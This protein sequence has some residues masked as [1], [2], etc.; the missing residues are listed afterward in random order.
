MAKTISGTSSANTLL[1]LIG[2]DLIYGYADN[3]KLY[4]YGGRDTLDGGLGADTLYGGT[5]ADVY[6]VDNVLDRVVEPA[7]AAH[8]IRLFSIG[9]GGQWSNTFSNLTSIEFGGDGR[10]VLF[11]SSASNVISGDTNAEFDVFRKD[12][13]TGIIQRVSVSGSGAQGNDS[14]FNAAMTPD[15]RYIAFESYAS[16]LVSN[17]TN[18]NTDIFLRDMVGGTLRRISTGANGE[19]V[20]TFGN[21]NPDITGNGRYV[22]FDSVNSY[23]AGDTNGTYDIY[24]KDTVSGAIDRVSLTAARGQANGNSRDAQISDDGK[25]LLFSSAASNLIVG[26][27]NGRTDLFARNLETGAVQRVVAA[28]AGETF[29]PWSAELSGN[30]RYV[31]FTSKASNLVAGDTNGVS[32]VFVKDLVTGT[33]KCASTGSNWVPGNNA[34]EFGSI[35]ADGRY[36][37]FSSW[38]EDLVGVTDYG[39]DVFVKD[40]LTGR[41]AI[42]STKPDGQIYSSPVSS[43]DWPR[44]SRDGQAI[45]FR[46]DDVLDSRDYPVDVGAGIFSE[47]LYISDN[48]LVSQI[49]EVRSS[50]SYVLPNYEVENLT[51]T[52]TANLSGEGNSHANYI[53]G[54]A[55]NN[56]LLGKDGN[57]T[58]NGGAGSDTLTGGA[59][60]DTYYVNSSGDRVVEAYLFT[61]EQTYTIDYQGTDCVISS[62]SFSLNANTGVTTVETLQLVSAAAING[63]GN[64]LANLIYAGDG[65]NVIDGLGG[66]D[67]VSYVYASAGVKV[68]LNTMAAQATGGS[69]ADTLLRIEGLVGS[70]YGDL[71]TGS[72]AANTLTGGLGNDSLLGGAGDDRLYGGDGSDLLR[73]G[74]GKD[75]LI[76]GAG[77]DIFDF[78]LLSEMGTSSSTWDVISD[79]VRGADKIDLLTLDANTATAANDAFTTIIASTAAF[80]GAGQLKLSGGVLYGNTDADATAEFAIQ[81]SGVSALSTADFVL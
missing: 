78:N 28:T 25:M 81:L 7:S 77:K 57:D 24:R 45:I 20:G 31:V 76:G 70:K 80:N 43:S 58:L 21:W 44:I 39:P 17:D 55:G 19:Q 50:V 42:V 34:S 3:D 72:D 79:F 1:G 51:L 64:A 38:A 32:D 6:I 5:G 2:E 36:V 18:Y 49:D 22:V 46:S 10:Y 61:G 14:S 29:Y 16:N 63:T 4:G 56:A 33:I 52:G 67:T 71:L 75:S 65:D 35:S 74:I 15:A 62:T 54:N 60:N 53:L 41:I 8:D 23:V 30:G 27:T 37:A 13:H 47:D 12:L 40:M 9:S 73:G 66:T 26:D 59:G 68:G 69:G 48:P 11:L